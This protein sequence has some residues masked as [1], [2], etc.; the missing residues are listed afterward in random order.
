[1][2]RGSCT[3]AQKHSIMQVPRYKKN[4]QSRLEFLRPIV[5]LSIQE[6]VSRLAMEGNSSL[7]PMVFSGRHHVK[8]LHIAVPTCGSETESRRQ[9]GPL[10]PWKAQTRHSKRCWM[11]MLQVKGGIRTKRLA[12]RLRPKRMSV[13]GLFKCLK[14]R[15]WVW[16]RRSRPSSRSCLRG[17]LGSCRLLFGGHQWRGPKSFSSWGEVLFS[18][19]ELK[20]RCA[21]SIGKFKQPGR[22]GKKF[23]NWVYKEY[24]HNVGDYS[25]QSW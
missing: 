15:L 19:S 25:P 13:A 1:M 2:G 4:V 22:R 7:L 8:W 24:N 20:R 17:T 16:G 14:E 18:K 23:C 3:V 6:S 21:S 5:N 12:S 10:R 9:G 11:S